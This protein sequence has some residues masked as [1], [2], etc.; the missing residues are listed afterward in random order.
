M[1]DKRYS[2][3]ALIDEVAVGTLAVLP[4]T[5]TMVRKEDNQALLK[6]TLG[7]E[8]RP[9]VPQRGIDIAEFAIILAPA[10]ASMHHGREVI[11]LMQIVKVQEEKE[12]MAG[13]VL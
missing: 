13:I 11:R 10:E 7:R 4:Q 12:G 6:E 5:L 1:H 8:K 3:R 2:N 9:K